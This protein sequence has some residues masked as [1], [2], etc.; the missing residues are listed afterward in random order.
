[1]TR[2]IS[3]TVARANLRA[4]TTDARP[5]TITF[6]IGETSLGNMLIARRSA[7]ICAILFGD[8]RDALAAD[9]ALRFPKAKLVQDRGALAGDLARLSRF[10]EKPAEGLDL[11][12]D[13]GGTPFQRRVWD[14]LRTIPAGVTMTYTDVASRIGAPKAV[15]AVARACAANPLALAVPCHRVVRSGGGLA[16]YRWGI[17]RKRALLAREAQA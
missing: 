1:M 2:S 14:A 17:E 3:E 16:G 8:D 12:L 10:V 4:G 6:A 5:A 7:G 15:R 13:I 9:L 11:P